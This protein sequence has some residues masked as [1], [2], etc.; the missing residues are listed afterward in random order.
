M[1]SLSSVQIC[2]FGLSHVGAKGSIESLDE[3]SREAQV[4]KLWFD[5][6]RNQVLEDFN[7]PFARKRQ[8]LALLADEDPPAEWAYRYGYPSDCVKA[9]FIVNPV[10]KEAAAIPFQVETISDGSS[11]SI[12]TDLENAVMVYTFDQSDPTL[13]SS[14]FIDALS[15]R[16]ASN[17]AF[18]ITGDPELSAQVFKIYQTVLRSATGSSAQEGI[19]Q[20]PRDA[21]WIRARF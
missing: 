6:S 10:G 11:K 18:Q 19:D 12:L 5:W 8:T 9:R 15:Y 13:F 7:W 17:I 20:L 2:N 4:C 14:K 3:A 16:V 21:E 1:P